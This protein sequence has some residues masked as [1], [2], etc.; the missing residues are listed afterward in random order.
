MS[1][2]TPRLQP[3]L[4]NAIST[5][6]TSWHRNKTTTYIYHMF[7][8]IWKSGLLRHCMHHRDTCLWKANLP[9]VLLSGVLHVK[10][11]YVGMLLCSNTDG[12]RSP[13]HYLLCL[14]HCR[15]VEVVRAVETLS[16]FRRTLLT[17]GENRGVP[18]KCSCL[19]RWYSIAVFSIAWVHTSIHLCGL[20]M[21]RLHEI[22]SFSQFS[23]LRGW[24]SGV[25]LA[26]GDIFA[27]IE[28]QLI[29][30]LWQ[31]LI[32]SLTD[33][34]ASYGIGCNFPWKSTTFRGLAHN[35]F[36]SI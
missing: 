17:E 16:I 22:E 2:K 19:G 4:L 3:T 10:R 8:S 35:Y 30:G 7:A 34:S 12:H 26:F 5:M 24:A 23:H 31:P 25:V 29:W 9:D 27:V 18:L 33:C 14:L 6:L 21:V 1:N 36:E 32:T 15:M 11:L 28:L 20:P 13:F